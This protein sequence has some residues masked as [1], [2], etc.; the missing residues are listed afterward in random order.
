MMSPRPCWRMRRRAR[1]RSPVMVRA[2]VSSMNSGTE[3]SFWLA[4][5]KR[6]K[7]SWLTSP[8]RAIGLGRVEADIGGERGLAHR[9]PAGEDHEVGGMQAAEQLVEV[10]E[11]GRDAGGAAAP[12]EGGLGHDDGLG[13]GLVEGAKSAL[14]LAAGGEIEERRVGKECR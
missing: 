13:E 4:W 14:G 3:A 9:G 1:V 5:T 7:S 6:S 11:A 12:L 8:R 2:G 10:V